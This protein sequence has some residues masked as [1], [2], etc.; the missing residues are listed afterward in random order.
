MTHLRSR[1]RY[2][3]GSFLPYV[4]LGVALASTDT[5]IFDHTLTEATDSIR[6]G[7]SYGLGVEWAASE[8]LRARLEYVR[9]EYGSEGYGSYNALGDSVFGTLETDTFSLGLLY[10][11]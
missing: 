11:F 10:A 3:F 5:S 6:A 7:L 2:A 9:D 4:S 1:F 8:Q